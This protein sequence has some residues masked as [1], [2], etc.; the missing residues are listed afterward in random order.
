MENT[1]TL[2]TSQI[3]PVLATV[4][5]LHPGHHT[6]DEIKQVKKNDNSSSS[7]IDEK[8]SI[9]SM[10]KIQASAGVIPYREDV[11]DSQEAFTAKDL[12][13]GIPF[14]ADSL[15]HEDGD[16]LAVRAL[17]VGTALGL[18]IAASNVYLGLKTGLTFGAQLFGSLLGFAAIKTM[19]K[20]LPLAFGGGYFG[21]KENVTVQS[22]ATGAS[23][24]TSMFVA[25]VPAMYRLGLLGASPQADFGRLFALTFCTAFY[26]CFFAIP[27]R[28][29]YILKQKLIFPTPTATALAIRSLHTA[30]GHDLAKKKK[31]KDFG[32]YFWSFSCLCFCGSICNGNLC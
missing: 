30:G 10:E 11:E 15:P 26:G 19:S 9:A 2:G 13:E 16:G 5:H 25:A 20:Y 22:A 17:V 21:P 18:I 28:K 3:N 6:E 14:S 27:L 12:A 1:D 31:D 24:L 32:Y 8:V 29:F 7:D 23:G 4:N